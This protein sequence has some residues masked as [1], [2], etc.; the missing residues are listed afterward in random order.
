MPPVKSD[1]VPLLKN[2]S[3]PM[4]W[5]N[6]QLNGANINAAIEVSK[7]C[8]FVTLLPKINCS[9]ILINTNKMNN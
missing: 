3:T 8:F 4:K 9:S 2:N 7:L 6:K 1:L 5:C